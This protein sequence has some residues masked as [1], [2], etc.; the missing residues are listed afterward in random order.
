MHNLQIIKLKVFYILLRLKCMSMVNISIVS[1]PTVIFKYTSSYYSLSH[2]SSVPFQIGSFYN[3]RHFF[4][5]C[6]ASIMIYKQALTGTDIVDL[7][8]YQILA[9]DY[10]EKVFFKLRPEV[11][12]ERIGQT[13]HLLGVLIVYFIILHYLQN[14]DETAGLE[15]N[16]DDRKQ[17]TN[18][19][20][21]QGYYQESADLVQRLNQ[22]RKATNIQ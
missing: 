10:Q 9:G 3:H 21:E 14:Q 15:G 7:S 5:G 13:S 18:K 16:Y 11:I 20:A 8:R 6:L 1:E 12:S 22:Q 19:D 2:Q 4:M 17:G